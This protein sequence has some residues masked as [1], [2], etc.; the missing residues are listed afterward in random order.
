MSA[1]L[2]PPPPGFAPEQLAF[3]RHSRYQRPRRRVSWWGL[4]VGVGV[5]L[6]IGLTYAWVVEPVREV[7]TQPRQLNR[8]ARADYVVAIAL[9]FSYDSD[10]GRAV[11]DLLALNL[12]PDPFQQVANIAC[13]L[14]STGY[15]DS[16]SGIRALR[17]LRTFYQL[18]GKTGCADQLIDDATPV[19]LA[20][21]VIPTN[22][23]TLIPPPT[24]T[25]TPAALTVGTP[26]APIVPT[27]L[28]RRTYEG[29]ILNTF[30]SLSA[31]GMIEVTVRDANGSGIPGQRVRVRWDGGSDEFSTGLKPDRG[32]GY[33]DFRMRSGFNYTIDMP[34][35]SDP[36]AQTLSAE[37]CFTNEGEEAL[38]GYRV[39]FRLVR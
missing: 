3:S 19:P 18:Q 6:A 16:T 8:A 17:T 21:L 20:T 22:T 29:Q 34:G 13:E 35:Q 24:K 11:E 25:P 5:G 39:V 4:L 30:C 15:V 12:G 7:D 9:R 31:S 36:I 33:A 28:P 23:P 38:R 27:A 1:P 14:A 2:P 10:L 37:P 26:A 32:D